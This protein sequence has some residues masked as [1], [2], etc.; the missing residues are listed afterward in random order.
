MITPK[1]KAI[2]KTVPRLV[3]TSL[4]AIF[5]ILAFSCTKQPII[6]Y[7]L[8]DIEG[9]WLVSSITR[10]V[11]IMQQNTFAVDDTVRIY[12]G[13]G[14][15]TMFI[16]REGQNRHYDELKEIHFYEMIG[17][18]ILED[19]KTF[20]VLADYV[21]VFELLESRKDQLILQFKGNDAKIYMQ[22]Q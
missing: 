8:D 11:I 6:E 12:K 22:K 14:D 4:F 16:S 7:D 20:K 15:V 21:Y 13:S 5:T 2:M 10:Q 18:P 17:G 3:R 19:R 9:K 1:N